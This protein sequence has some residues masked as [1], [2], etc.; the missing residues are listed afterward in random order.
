MSILS[1]LIVKFTYIR[2]IDRTIA[3]AVSITGLFLFGYE[4]SGLAIASYARNV[5]DIKVDPLDFQ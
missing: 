2:T 1:L 4:I 5:F 3:V